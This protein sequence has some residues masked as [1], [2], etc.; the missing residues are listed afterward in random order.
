[1]AKI[2]YVVHRYAPYPG[3][4]ENYV[5]DMAEETVRRGH[6]V[7]VLAGEH[8]GDLNGV[9]VTRNFQIMGSELFDL[10]VVHARLL[11]EQCKRDSD[12]TAASVMIDIPPRLQFFL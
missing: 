6:D 7:T 3:G 9:K 8:K 10:I 2:L 4:S 11:F 5:R 1:M 12:L